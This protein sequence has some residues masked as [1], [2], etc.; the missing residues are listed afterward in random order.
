MDFRLR[1]HMFLRSF[2]LQAGWNYVKYQNLG[3]A[4]VMLPFLRKLY[5]QDPDTLSA[6]IKRRYLDTFNTH[7]V[8]A[9]FCYGALAKQEEIIAK[10]APLTDYKEQV[11]EWMGIR[12]GLSITAAS[13]GDRLFWGTLKPLTLLLAIFLWLLFGINFFETATLQPVSNWYIFL[14]L[15]LIFLI[16]NCVA[17]YVRWKGI[18][19]GY[20]ADETTCFGL[21]RFDWNRTIYHTKRVG[22]VFTSALIVFGVYYYF[23]QIPQIDLRFITHAVLVLCCVL[24]AFIARYLRIPN[25][26]LYII[27]VVVFN[28]VCLF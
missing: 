10:A 1:L 2:F 3:F 27:A 26:Y 22:L 20:Q 6:I 14:P 15:V 4:F 24:L 5:H 23:S 19:L 21:T 17:W 18:E 7:P 28:I 9:S 11:N 8:M 13:I 16:Y 12:R 25:V